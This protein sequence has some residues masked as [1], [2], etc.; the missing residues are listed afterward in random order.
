MSDLG[1]KLNSFVNEVSEQISG[2]PNL[3][4]RIIRKIIIICYF[5]KEPSFSNYSEIMLKK[6][7]ETKKSLINKVNFFVFIKIIVLKA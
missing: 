7:E 4:R 1:S 5:I 6:L 3:V 2:I